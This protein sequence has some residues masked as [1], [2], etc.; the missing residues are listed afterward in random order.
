MSFVGGGLRFETGTTTLAFAF[1]FPSLHFFVSGNVFYSFLLSMGLDIFGRWV[2]IPTHPLLIITP[3]RFI[4]SKVDLN[5]D[6]QEI[7]L[8]RYLEKAQTLTMT[9]AY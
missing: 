2:Q 7:I 9:G 5:W 3:R 4:R 6:S 8:I 1:T